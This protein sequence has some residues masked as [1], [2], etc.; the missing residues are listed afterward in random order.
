METLHEETQNPTADA[1]AHRLRRLPAISLSAMSLL[2]IAVAV[3]VIAALALTLAELSS[4]TGKTNRLQGLE[5]LRAGATKAADSYGVQ[6]GSYNYA[7]LHGPTAPW[8]VIETNATP[9]FKVD[10]QRTSAALEP[11]I[12]AYKAAARASVPTSAVSSVS[13]SKAVVLLLL[14]QTVTNSTQK[15]GPQT[16]QFLV[17]M[18][19]LHQKGKWLIDNVQASV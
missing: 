13:S 10:Y 9:T 17:V 16:Q 1:S 7:N 14:S 12:V 2:A 6:F 8:T 4:Q 15:S 11:T 19:L 5:S 3:V 18:T